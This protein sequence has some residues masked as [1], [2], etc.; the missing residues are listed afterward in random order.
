MDVSRAIA[1]SDRV[2]AR[3][4]VVAAMLGASLAAAPPGVPAVGFPAEAALAQ[5]PAPCSSV[6]PC[7]L[8]TGLPPSYNGPRPILTLDGGTVVFEH[9]ADAG[10]IR[11]LYSVPVR[12]GANP[13]RLD[14]P[15]A[16]PSETGLINI[17]P[18]GQRVLYI[19]ESTQG[20]ALFSVPINGPASAAVRLSPAI[21]GKFK[22]SP[23]SRLV[24]FQSTTS[25][26]RAAPV[27]GPESLAVPLTRTATSTFEISSNSRNL[28]Y[29]ADGAGGEP[30]LFRVPLTLNPDPD[31]QPTSLSGPM[32]EGGY[33]HT[34]RLPAGDGPVVYSAVQETPDIRELYSVG[35]GGGNRTKLNVPLPPSWRVGVGAQSSHPSGFHSGYG[36]SDDGRRV[37]YGIRSIDDPT[38]HQ[39][40][41]V[42]TTGPASASRRLDV[43]TPGTSPATFHITADS[44][45]VVY[46][47]SDAHAGPARTFSVPIDGPAAARVPVNP[48]DDEGDFVQISPDGQRL[49]FRMLILNQNA[50]LSAPVDDAFPSP[51]MVRL[52]GAERLKGSVE[53]DPLGQRVAY[54]AQEGTGGHD[55]F[56]SALESQSRFNL[57]ATLNADLIAFLQVSVQHAV[58]W[59]EV[60]DDGYQLYSS[61]LVPGTSG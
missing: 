20:R 41:S 17:T 55:V 32:I 52:N 25:R 21:L 38:Q 28:V 34:F 40:F 45:H 16:P 59:A 24:T 51:D 9:V 44:R 4:V 50:A 48:G 2:G 47:V 14:P 53:F 33:V 57:T 36:I 58:Y 19:A 6:Q 56:S 37:V 22:I 60:S 39:L 18:D 11:E 46:P 10:N 12:G 54:V 1:I 29:I 13:V 49:V 8:S 31:Q 43:T 42:P 3:K 15:Q 61:R 7:R 5:P 26:V 27:A 30:E 35:F 23:D